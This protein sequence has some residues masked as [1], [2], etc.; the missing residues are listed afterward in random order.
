MLVFA[1]LIDMR[2]NNREGTALI[3]SDFRF[4][5]VDQTLADYHG[6]RV[7]QYPGVK[8]SD[9]LPEPI[10]N[11]V[12]PLY[13]HVL[14]T[15][16]EVPCVEFYIPTNQ[17]FGINRLCRA[18]YK[19]EGLA[20]LLAKVSYLTKLEPEY[21]KLSP[22]PQYNRLT[23]AEMS[24]LKLLAIGSSTKE[25]AERLGLS[26]HTI[27]CHRKH[28]CNKL[29]IHSTAELVSYATQHLVERPLNA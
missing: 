17:I 26:C 15:R 27:A 11:I 20:G 28:I 25:I 16:L 23:K 12:K 19:P 6:L 1:F 14:K 2:F 5:S 18:R 22:T 13:D 9:V 24:V 7:E 3:S 29:A 4:I 8:V 10:W 21:L